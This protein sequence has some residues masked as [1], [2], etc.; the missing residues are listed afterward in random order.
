MVNFTCP[1]GSTTAECGFHENIGWRYIYW[2]LGGLTLAMSILR[3][4]FR[5]YETPKYLLGKGRDEA[6][7]KVVSQIAAR[8]GKTTWLTLSHF[9]AIDAQLEAAGRSASGEADAN[10]PGSSSKTI[11][12][13]LLSKYAPDNIRGL[14]ATPR[15]AL[16]TSMMIVLWTAIGM[17]YPL[18]FSFI[19][20]YL[21]RKGI[22]TGAGGL[23]ITYRNYT[24][25]AV[26][27][28]PAAILG[29]YTVRMKHLGRK[30]TGALACICTGVFLFLYTQVNNPAGVLGLS[31]AISF[32][33]FLV[34]ALLYSYTPELFPAPIRGTGN[35]VMMTFNRL[36]GVMAPLIPAYMGIDTDLPI[37]ISAS[38]I[39]AAG[40]LCLLLPYE[41]RGR[42]AS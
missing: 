27:G 23:N 21:E 6:A 5:M 20:F 3:F 24:I 14:F 34:Y 30:G 35:G 17:S 4:S 41:S 32:F 38:L 42:A 11:V 37:W 22:A 36:A 28:M 7:V 8:D 2:T 18:Y 25:Q 10:A 1:A 19:P 12:R 29:G 26:C 16:S 31:C 33:Q 13:R 9:Q 15:M 40:F 39:T